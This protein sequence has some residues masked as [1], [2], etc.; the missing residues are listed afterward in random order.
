MA[1]TNLQKVIGQLRRYGQ[2]FFDGA[3]A[4]QVDAAEEVL[5]RAKYYTPVETGYL[6]GTGRVEIELRELRRAAARIVFDAPYSTFVHER[7]DLHHAPPTQAKFLQ[8]AVDELER[9]MTVVIGEGA[10]TAAKRRAR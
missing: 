6:K 4:A 9:R 10:V 5:A 7:L 3:A 1:I 8:R 2:G